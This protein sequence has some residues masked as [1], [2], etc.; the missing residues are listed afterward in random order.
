MSVSVIRGPRPE[1][2]SL[3]VVQKYFSRSCRARA[4]IACCV[5]LPRA[6]TAKNRPWKCPGIS[7]HKVCGDPVHWT[8]LS[9]ILGYKM[10]GTCFFKFVVWGW[11]PIL[12]SLLPYL[13]FSLGWMISQCIIICDGWD[14]RWMPGANEV[15]GCPRKYLNFS[16]SSPNIFDDFFLFSH[17]PIFLCPQGGCPGPSHRSHPLCMPMSMWPFIRNQRQSLC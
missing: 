10:L 11:R 3:L 4:T 14:G 13:G 8:S 17:S 7:F 5:R 6:S 15:F 1:C 9:D 2:C 16:N 12:S